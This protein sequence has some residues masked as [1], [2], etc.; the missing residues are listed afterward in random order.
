MAATPQHAVLQFI[1]LQSR[2]SYSLDAY[3]SDVANGL[4]TFDSGIGASATSDTSYV[5]PEN[6]VLVDVSFATGLADT[7]RI[8]LVRNQVPTGDTFD[9]AIH[10][11]GIASR[12]RLAKVFAKGDK[13]ALIQLA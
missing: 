11:D 2:R 12:P 4:T 1:G 6:M 13:I 3:V 8:R 9:Y 5:C 10:D 7:K